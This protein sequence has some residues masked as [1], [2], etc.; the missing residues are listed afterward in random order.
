MPTTPELLAVV[1]KEPDLQLRTLY[2]FAAESGARLNELLGVC[3]ESIDFNAG[4]VFLDHSINEENTFRPYK[5]K[6]QRRFVEASDELLEL[7]GIWMKA[8]MF[9]VTHEI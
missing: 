7:F 8:Q 3:Y 6:T 1:N 4:G 2:K 5:V 9:P